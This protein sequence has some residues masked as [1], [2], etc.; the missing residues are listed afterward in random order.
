MMRAIRLRTLSLSLSLSLLAAAGACTEPRVR[1]TAAPAPV[2][3]ARLEVSDT[4]PAAGSSI[5]VR[6][7]VV[8]KSAARVAS[9]VERVAY[10]TLSLRY[11]GDVTLDDGATRVTNPTSGLIRSAGVRA[12]GFGG[13]ALAA[14]RFEVRRPSALASLRLT[15]DE[16]HTIDHSDASP[17]VSVAREPVARRR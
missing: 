1:P 6:V 12:G 8:G 2:L 13:G 15:I 17:M 11:L 14:Y 4:L 16:L 7:R 3:E 10:D 5:D 9:F